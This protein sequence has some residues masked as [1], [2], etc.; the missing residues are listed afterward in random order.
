MLPPIWQCSLCKTVSITYKEGFVPINSKIFNQLIHVSKISF[1]VSNGV[2]QGGVL[3]P[4]LFCVYLDE[5]LLRLKC[6][7]LGCHIGNVSVPAVSYADDIS[8]MAPTVSSLK[9]MLN[10]IKDFG[11]E[12]CVK[13]NPDK[14]KLLVFGKVC[15]CRINI[16]FDG[17]S[18]SQTDFA[19]HLGHIYLAQ[20]LE[21]KALTK[22]AVTLF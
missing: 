6:S 7:G 1:H 9:C 4:I 14:R 5:L 10:I 22:F 16:D 2:K 20:T 18:I 21:Q 3:S 11:Q 12:Y 15:N 13:V 8:L 19:D 17:Y